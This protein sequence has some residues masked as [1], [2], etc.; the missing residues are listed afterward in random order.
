M[1]DK[2]KIQ[3]SS[4]SDMENEDNPSMIYFLSV[5]ITASGA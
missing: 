5:P 1:I 2:T 4:Y 3:I